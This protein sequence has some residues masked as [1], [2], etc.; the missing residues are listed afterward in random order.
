MHFRVCHSIGTSRSN[1][2]SSTWTRWR[3]P[4]ASLHSG[5]TFC[6]QQTC[7]A[8]I[9]LELFQHFAWSCRGEDFQLL[10]SAQHAYLLHISSISLKVD[11]LN[12]MKHL[13]Q[14]GLGKASEL[15]YRPE[16]KFLS[17]K[18]FFLSSTSNELDQRIAR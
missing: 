18:Q 5:S 4:A 3:K 9:L 10:N 8:E 6:L 2:I 17:I 15:M 13:Y 7:S 12:F 11:A 1:L 14:L 16:K